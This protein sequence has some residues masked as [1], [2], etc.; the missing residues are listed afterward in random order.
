MRTVKLLILILAVAASSFA[1]EYHG[2]V[3]V[4][5]YYSDDSSSA[6]KFNI[7]TT[8]LRLDVDKLNQAGTLSFHF[9]GRE[10]NNLGSKDYSSSIKNERIDTIS[11]E[12]L[13]P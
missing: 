8:R 6:Y 2:L 7:L 4:D 5:D 10:R 9:D 1:I 3:S 12:Y 13:G 11:L